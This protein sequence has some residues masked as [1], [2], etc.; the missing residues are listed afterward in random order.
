VTSGILD[1][2]DG[3]LRDYETGADAM[4]WVPGDRRELRP[5]S[6]AARAGIV[7]VPVPVDTGELHRALNEL[8]GMLARALCPGIEGAAKVFHDLGAAL[9][10]SL[11]RRC[12]TCHPGRKPKPLT[13]DGHEYQRRLAARRRRR[14]GR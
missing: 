7:L 6:P 8:G 4:R 2:I 14:H 5:A 12:L 1:S 3:A 9:Y 10:P 11:H 13:V